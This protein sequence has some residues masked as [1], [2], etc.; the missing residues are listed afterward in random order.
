MYYVYILKSLRDGL[1][2]TGYTT[3]L[4]KRF[5]RHQSG[6]V[7]STRSRRP[8]QIIFYEAYKDKRDAKRREIY[9]KPR[10]AKHHYV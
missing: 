6:E 3:D 10:K 7:I 8:L 4:R 1:L 5:A 2:Y 9:L